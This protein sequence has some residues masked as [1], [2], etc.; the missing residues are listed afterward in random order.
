MP[1][2]YYQ[3]LGVAK[4]ASGDE[5]KK[6]YRKLAL[7]YHPDR[8]PEDKKKDYEERFKEISQ[9]YRVLSDK[10]KRAQYDQ[11]GQTLEGA[12]FGYGF[13]ERDF[14]SFYDVFGGQDTFEGLGFDRIFEEIF[15]FGRRSARG[16][17][18]QYGD[19]ITLDLEISLE[20]AFGGLKKEIVLRKM[21]VCPECQGRGGQSIKECPT[22]RG[23]GYEQTKRSGLFGLFIQQKICSQCHG[24]GKVP[25]KICHHCHGEGR[26]KQEKTIKVSIP[27]GIDDGQVL[28]LSNQGQAGAYGAP[29]G[30][31]FINIHLKPHKYFRRYSDEI[32]FNLTIDFTQAIL[33]DKIEIPT[34]DGSIRLKIPAGIQPEEVI[35]LKGKG[36]SRLY[37]R[38]RGDLLVRIKVNIPKKISREQKKIIEE[39]Q[40]LSK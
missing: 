29:A 27:A 6:A 10:E 8:A 23:S 9:A 26:I 24:R 32:Y 15:G 18:A 1:K 39:C 13:S 20:E 12:P 38:G 34:L 35:K 31:L 28:K 5:I 17:T 3:I 19:D 2:D 21:A 7:Q 36:M 40:K 14:R 4:T 33:G 25:E 37:S 30:D 11:Y 16:Q 22:C